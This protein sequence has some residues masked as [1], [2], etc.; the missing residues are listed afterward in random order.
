MTTA[1][2]LMTA[3]V[4][5]ATTVVLVRFARRTDT[6]ERVRALAPRPR[7]V[8]TWVA[9]P[10]AAA[11][12]AADIRVDVVTAIQWWLLATMLVTAVG[13][14][15]S[16]A[17]GIVAAL[18]AVLGVPTAL[19]AA[20]ERARGRLAAAIPEALERCAMEL[21]GGGTV[22]TAI[23]A[24]GSGRGALAAD[25]RRVQERC[26]LGASLDDAVAQ[27]AEERAAPGVRAAAGALALGASV[28]GACADALDGLATSLRG[29]LGVIAEARSLS[30]QARLSAIVVGA[31]PIG[32]L[33]WSTVVDPGPL[34][35][36]FGSHAGRACLALACGLEA[37]AVVWMRRIFREDAAW[38]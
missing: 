1:L 6:V 29:R 17:L 37:L 26:A 36:L 12:A 14:V 20:R 10:V 19:R 18:G 23:D 21:R 32:Y 7:G 33:A 30:A 8:P 22:N 34:Q 24:L 5:T 13:A 11:L 35:V 28:G 31:A 27:W 4:G 38:S 9:R 16:P 15:V 25:F 3:G 2:R